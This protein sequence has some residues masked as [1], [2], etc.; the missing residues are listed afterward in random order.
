MY[1]KQDFTVGP[2][3]LTIIQ[4][5]QDERTPY[6]DMI[7]DDRL[8]HN[9][10]MISTREDF[11][12]ETLSAEFWQMHTQRDI[13]MTPHSSHF[14]LP[15]FQRNVFVSLLVQKNTRTVM[16]FMPKDN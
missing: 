5:K 11:Y 13:L 1:L 2:Y 7:Q 12:D 8:T 14:V 4:P 16:D 10:M 15:A 3:H 9:S 6:L